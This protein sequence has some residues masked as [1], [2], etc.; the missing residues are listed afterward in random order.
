VSV[1]LRCTNANEPV[2]EACDRCSSRS[3]ARVGR[4]ADADRL[5]RWLGAEQ[6]C[7]E[8]DPGTLH[9]YPIAALL[10]AGAVLGRCI[11][12]R[13]DRGPTLEQNVVTAWVCARV[14]RCDLGLQLRDGVPRDVSE[15][16]S[17]QCL[18]PSI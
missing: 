9:A 4:A 10:W 5:A 3:F 8:A 17:I 1:D 2:A 13:Y 11:V 18:N 6:A 16:L 15:P 14:A 12:T 7:N